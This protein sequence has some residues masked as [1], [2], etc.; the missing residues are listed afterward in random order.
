MRDGYSTMAHRIHIAVRFIDAAPALHGAGVMCIVPDGRML[1]LKR[2]VGAAAHPETWCFPGG[3]I[4]PGEGARAAARREA[5]EE[6]GV[7]VPAPLTGPIDTRMGFATYLAKITRPFDAVLN[8]EHTGAVWAL[9]KDAPQPLH[10]GV[11]A[12]LKMLASG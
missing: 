8:D 12:T 5:R 4:E 6:V 11:A 1:F 3:S 7:N 9:A 2:R 10:P